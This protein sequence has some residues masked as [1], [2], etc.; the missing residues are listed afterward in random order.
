MRNFWQ[1]IA[2]A[3]TLGAS[4]SVFAATMIACPPL[5]NLK[6][7]SFNQVYLDNAGN[8]GVTYKP[9]QNYGT[10]YRWSFVL[11]NSDTS[12][13]VTS[14]DE[15]KQLGNLAL[16]TIHLSKVPEVSHDQYSTTIDCYYTNDQG[17]GGYAEADI[18]KN[19]PLMIMRTN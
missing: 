8:W 5:D 1:T 7:A 18:Q 9:E 11:G 2:F 3:L 15:A 19:N 17:I 10:P 4:Y 6:A 12:R 14:E 16:S 13:Q